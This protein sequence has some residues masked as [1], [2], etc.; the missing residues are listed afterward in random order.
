MQ[1]TILSIAQIRRMV[2]S[3][4]KQEQNIAQIILFGSYATGNPHPDSDIDLV[5]LLKDKGPAS[6]YRERLNRTVKY[7]TMLFPVRLKIDLDLKVYTL[8]EWRYLLSTMSPFA[9]TIR[10]TGIF[11][12]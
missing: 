12:K 1:N 4:L 11:I 6:S 2:L 3:C 10:K 9:L 5:I 7:Y 8:D